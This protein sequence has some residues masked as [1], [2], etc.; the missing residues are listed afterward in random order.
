[1]LLA[2]D[3]ATQAVT[4]AVHDGATVVAEQAHTDTR[5]HTE[6][7]APTIRDVLREAGLRPRDLSAVAVGVGPGPFTGLRVGIVTA[8]TMGLALGVPVHGVCSLDA[9]AHATFAAG[10]TRRFL[11]ATDARRKEVYWAAYDVTDEG[12]RRTDGPDVARPAELPG[13][14]RGLPTAGR[15]TELYPEAL[16]HALPQLDVSAGALATFVTGALRRGE[17]LLEPQPLYLRRPDAVPQAERTPV[18]P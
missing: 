16:P 6:L 10:H 7:L 2:I 18:T 9:L 12:V 3:T 5:R 1:M 11:V 4:V 15:G 13:H 17:S 14:L 8:R